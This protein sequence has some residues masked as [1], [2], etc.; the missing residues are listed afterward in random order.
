VA[1]HEGA[2]SELEKTATTLADEPTGALDTERGKAVMDLQ[3]RLE[4]EREA[5]VIVVTHDDRMLDG[6]ARVCRMTDG[7]I[8]PGQRIHA[9]DASALV[10]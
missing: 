5:A 10:R 6:C 7:R 3:R 4:R 8:D 9:A 1:F 2:N